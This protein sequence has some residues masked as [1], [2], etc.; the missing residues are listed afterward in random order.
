METTTYLLCAPVVGLL[1]GDEHLPDEVV[2]ID[3]R[4]TVDEREQEELEP[5][6]EGLHGR[7]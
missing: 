1:K 6:V 5:L 2:C 4:R 3:K 7:V